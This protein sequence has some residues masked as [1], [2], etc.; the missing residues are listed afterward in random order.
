MYG[1]KIPDKGNWTITE[2]YLRLAW[3]AKNSFP[4]DGRFWMNPGGSFCS[5]VMNS[6]GTVLD[7]VWPEDSAL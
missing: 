1:I 5:S 4:L 7:M 6:T 3:V 2:L